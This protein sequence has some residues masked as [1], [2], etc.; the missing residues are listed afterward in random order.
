MYY[1]EDYSKDMCRKNKQKNCVK[2]Q[3]NQR[4][5]KR[6]NIVKNVANEKCRKN[7]KNYVNFSQNIVLH[8]FHSVFNKL[9]AENVENCVEK[10]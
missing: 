1:A 8:V 9:K 3:K 10:V 6:K 5:Y 2:S 4:I 7:Q